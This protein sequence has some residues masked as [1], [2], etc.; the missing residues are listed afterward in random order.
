MGDVSCDVA[1]VAYSLENKYD[2]YFNLWLLGDG[3]CF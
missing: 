2:C 3:M 1:A